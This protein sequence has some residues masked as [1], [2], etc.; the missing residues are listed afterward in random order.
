VGFAIV[1]SCL[2]AGNERA[3]MPE[4]AKEKPKPFQLEERQKKLRVKV[5]NTVC[6]IRK[7]IALARI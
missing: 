4:R 7:E 6:V 3:L 2:P 5:G 1:G